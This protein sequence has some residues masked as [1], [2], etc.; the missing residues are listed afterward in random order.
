MSGRV[1]WHRTADRNIGEIV[2]DYPEKRNAVTAAMA[3]A[4]CDAITALERDESVKVIVISGAGPDLTS[5]TDAGESVS[6]FPAPAGEARPRPPNQRGRFQAA[7]LWWGHGGL[8]SRILHCSKITVAAAKGLC[9]ETGVYIALYSDLTV[10]SDTA[11]FGIPPWRHIGVNG[12]ISMLVAA[13]GLK[14]A[15]ELIYCGGAWDARTALSYG[16][17]DGVAKPSDHRATID[18]LA[19]SCAMIMRDAIAAEKQVVFAALARMQIDTGLAA[20][21]VI[22]GWGTNIHFRAGEFNFL[23]QARQA[24]IGA[25]LRAGRD[26]F[27]SDLP[28]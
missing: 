27:E 25:A 26:H 17:I 3:V 22:S 21:A 1:T 10:A 11:V 8:F 6:R 20:A 18:S 9:L 16:L 2:I 4:F 12:D 24:G 19:G 23:R 28:A 13:V 14:R 7:N 15:K 5:G